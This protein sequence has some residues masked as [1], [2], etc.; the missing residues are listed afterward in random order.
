VEYILYLLVFAMT[1]SPILPHLKDHVSD[2]WAY[3]ANLG[4]TGLVMM[5]VIWC[6][7]KVVGA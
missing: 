2:Y 7:L 5:G 3:L 4:V 6:L 1:V